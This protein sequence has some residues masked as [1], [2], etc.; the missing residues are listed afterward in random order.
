MVHRV[1]EERAPRPGL[2]LAAALAVTALAYANAPEV[3]FVWDD[4]ALIEQEER[5]HQLWPLV[6]YFRARFWG[7]AL[8]INPPSYYRPLVTLSFALDWVRSDG[9]PSA[10]HLTNV[11]FHLLAVAALFVL[12]RRRG[13]SPA[14]AFAL[15]AVFGTFTRLTEAVTWISG[16]TDVFAG[17]AVLW[18]LVVQRKGG[19]ALW[20]SAAAGGLLLLGLLSKEVA[21]AGLAAVALREVYAAVK[22]EQ[23]WSAAGARLAPVAGAFAVWAA[24]RAGVVEPLSLSGRPLTDRLVL[25]AESL[26]TYAWMLLTP[27]NSQAMIGDA[28]QVNGM[29]VT[30]GVGIAVWG[31]AVLVRIR[32]RAGA[33]VWAAVTLGALALL[34]VL[35]LIPTNYT[36]LT[37]D[38]FLYL[39]LAALLWLL[40][41]LRAPPVPLPVRAAAA[42][43]LLVSLTLTTHLRNRAWSNEL[44]FWTLTVA[45]SDNFKAVGALA[46]VYFERSFYARARELFVQSVARAEAKGRASGQTGFIDFDSPR[47]SIAKCDEALGHF[48]AAQKAYAELEAAHPRWKRLLYNQ[49]LLRLRQ[50]DF[51]GALQQVARI[52]ALL[53]ADDVVLAGL[54]AAVHKAQR[55]A[56]QLAPLDGTLTPQQRSAWL[57]LFDEHGA[58]ALARRMAMEQLTDPQLAPD[59]RERAAGYLAFRG[60]EREARLAVEQLPE[61]KRTAL[62]A[63]LA[64]RLAGAE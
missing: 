31:L 47:L 2:L 46:D 24:L 38:R 32:R 27:W 37:N 8:E 41:P 33:D 23:A 55:D 1:T 51:E 30:A 15:A 25:A 50:L 60:E 16:R 34:P 29:L 5:M 21:L 18:A 26:A 22:K 62:A 58:V 48:D 9:A 49:V 64:E 11:F 54:E 43:A 12:V 63:V 61:P 6:D 36:V 40:A 20:R 28:S 14:W 57:D 13:A 53:G 42:G 35:H 45:Q 52:R 10:F 7:G 17:A 44:A 39:P 56:E 59:E 3:G 19:D 4:H